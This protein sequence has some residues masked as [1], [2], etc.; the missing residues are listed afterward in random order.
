VESLHSFIALIQ[1]EAEHA[2]AALAARQVRSYRARH[3]QPAA[4]C[5]LRPGIPV[6][7][8][9]IRVVSIIDW[10]ERSMNQILCCRSFIYS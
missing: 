1:K 5:G 7:A 4:A 6:I 3:V 2:R 9:N 10:C 8:E